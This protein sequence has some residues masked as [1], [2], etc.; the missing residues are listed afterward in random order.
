MLRLFTCE[1]ET[2]PS[3][4]LDIRGSAGSWDLISWNRASPD[5]WDR[6]QKQCNEI[7]LSKAE[8]RLGYTWI[9]RDFLPPPEPYQI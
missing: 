2:H 9:P 4:G 5:C 1:K 6:R 8:R 3:S 7:G